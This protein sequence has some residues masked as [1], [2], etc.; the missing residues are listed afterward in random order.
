MV[1]VRS[2][3]ARR[4]GHRRWNLSACPRCVGVAAGFRRREFCPRGLFPRGGVSSKPLARRTLR[5]W[6][7]RVERASR[8]AAGIGCRI[9]FVIRRS[10]IHAPRRPSFRWIQ[11]A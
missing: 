5:V 1:G 6:F 3:G 7:L 9:I 2:R 8:S 10:S 11:D 4:P